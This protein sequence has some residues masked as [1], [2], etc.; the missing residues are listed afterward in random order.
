MDSPKV[1]GETNNIFTAE[2][3]KFDTKITSNSE[4]SSEMNMRSRWTVFEVFPTSAVICIQKVL[5]ES[6][7]T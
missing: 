5:H 2:N 1:Y 4:S 3:I 7:T 6:E